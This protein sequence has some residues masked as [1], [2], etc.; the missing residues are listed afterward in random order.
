MTSLCPVIS[1]SV[2]GLL[3][4]CGPEEA[5][6][7]LGKNSANTCLSLLVLR[8]LHYDYA[9]SGTLQTLEK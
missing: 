2:V 4:F 7:D 6:E 1:E 5:T 8:A 3:L 9:S